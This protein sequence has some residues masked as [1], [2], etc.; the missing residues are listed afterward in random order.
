[1]LIASAQNR[2][3]VLYSSSMVLAMSSKV[4]FLKEA[5]NLRVL[6]LR[7]IVASYFLDPQSELILSPSQESLEGLLGFKFFLQKEHPSEARIVIH[8]YKTILSPADAYVS[9]RAE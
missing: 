6:E 3:G 7:P 5:F 2:S 1:M 9:Y 8:N 4:L